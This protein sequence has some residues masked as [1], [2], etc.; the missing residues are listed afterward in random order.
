MAGQ[1]LAKATVLGIRA[2]ALLCA[3]PPAASTGDNRRRIEKAVRK[4]S[5]KRHF[6]TAL[7]MLDEP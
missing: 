1:R 6:E 7:P 2:Q 4:R 5:R 3:S